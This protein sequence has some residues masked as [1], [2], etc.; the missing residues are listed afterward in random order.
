M[1]SIERQ[2]ATIRGSSLFDTEWYLNHYPDV[3]VLD[4]DPV[5]HYVRYGAKLRRDPHPLFDAAWYGR[6]HADV[7][8]AGLDPLLH[9]LTFGRF[10]G[11]KTLR[12][13]GTHPTYALCVDRRGGL[14]HKR[15]SWDT[16]REARF[17]D[18]LDGLRKQRTE[19]LP[20]ASVIMPTFNRAHALEGAIA[21]VVAQSHRD[22]ELLIVDDGSTDHTGSVVEPW[23][24]DR[25]IRYLTQEHGGVAKARNTGLHAAT[26]PY[27]FYL[28]SDNSWREDF[29]YTMLAYLS[30]TGLDAACCGS[31]CYDDHGSTHYRGDDFS[32]AECLREN[33]VDMNGFGHRRELVAGS[34]QFD[35]S[36]LRLVDWDFILRLTRDARTA[37]APFCGVRYYDGSGGGR[38][39]HTHYL[40]GSL[41]TVAARIRAKHPQR[42]PERNQILTAEGL[43]ETTALD[44]MAQVQPD[45]RAVAR[46][47][48]YDRRVGYVVWDWPAQSQT[49]VLNEIHTLIARG[50][51][52]AVYYKT[53][54]DTPATLDFQVPTFQIEDA[55]DLSV[56]VAEHARSVLHSPFVYPTT[57]LLTWPCSMA[58]GIPFTFM[59]GGV[60]ISHY[61]NMKRN[62]VG[63]VASSQNCLGVITLG[64]YHRNFL[65][66]QGVP[67]AKIVMERQAVA[68]PEFNPRY[69]IAPRPRITS[70]A[71][72]IEKKGLRYLVEAA[73]CIPGADFHLYGY[74]PLEGELRIQARRLGL[75]N[76]HFMQPLTDPMSLHAAYARADLFVLPCVR[77][78]NGDM[79]GLPTVILEAMGSGVP[80]I[81]NQIS[82]IPDV[83]VDGVTGLLA[84]PEDTASLVAKLEQAIALTAEERLAMIQA[85]REFV[86]AYAG[87]ERTVGT[88]ER[89]WAG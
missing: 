46:R 27:Q 7:E 75:T 74:G 65:V 17:L 47:A 39:S 2:I 48:T 81:S 63:E 62:R 8:R 84:V 30:I 19:P 26:C 28:D 10:E 21:S 53:G 33:Y 11:R 76:V 64:T 71:R 89:I 36:L 79:D 83:I 31:Y 29:L 13:G 40:D 20:G 72:F 38:V 73:A 59:P 52:V 22:W 56:L 86:A 5:E 77:A 67:A 57:T 58:T 69:R 78:A 50:V 18:T 43:L 3:A 61:E 35:E 82:N 25:R 41:D 15:D 42:Q 32:W 55:R 88:L 68:L 60:D 9:F 49:F 85:A 66:E 80:V 14:D 34:G 70:I 12:V 54:A 1:S 16:P 24:S 51:D 87:A 37:Y 44:R 4:M 6:H 45:V 23:L